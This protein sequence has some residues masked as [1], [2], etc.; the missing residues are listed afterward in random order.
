M[1]A[2]SGDWRSGTGSWPTTVR[3]LAHHVLRMIRPLKQNGVMVSGDLD[4]TVCRI[5]TGTGV[6]TDPVKMLELGADSGIVTDDYYLRVRMG[7]HAREL[8]FPTVTVNHGVAE[9]W[10]IRNLAAYLKREFPMLDVFHIPQYCA[11]TVLT[12]QERTDP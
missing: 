11:Y 4:R 5:A 10:G 7:V 1:T 6:T 2:G 9:E 8:D 12:N 3:D